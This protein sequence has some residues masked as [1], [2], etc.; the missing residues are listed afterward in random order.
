MTA[1]PSLPP[2]FLRRPLR[3]V[4]A[5]LLLV[6]GD[7]D[8]SGRGRARATETIGS[9]A[10]ARHRRRSRR[11]RRRR[12]QDTLHAARERNPAR[13]RS[14]GAR[15]RWRTPSPRPSGAC[16]RARIRAAWRCR[17]DRRPG[18]SETP[19]VIFCCALRAPSAAS[20]P[21]AARRSERGHRNLNMRISSSG[22]RW[23]SARD[24]RLAGLGQMLKLM[25]FAPGPLALRRRPPQRSPRLPP[26]LQQEPTLSR[27]SA[28]PSTIIMK[29]PI[30]PFRACLR[31]PGARRRP[32]VPRRSR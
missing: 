23:V 18:A 6:H 31:R 10:A 32:A 21:E 19:M 25:A 17:T 12:D 1:P 4:A 27:S 16:A 28:L 22:R 14:A 26:A 15:R 8:A 29:T 9:A 30:T 5:D 2:S 7:V 3:D 24:E 11:R 20:T 13:H